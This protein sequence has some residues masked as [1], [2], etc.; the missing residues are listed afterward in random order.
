MDWAAPP[1]RSMSTY[2]KRDLC[3]DPLWTFGLSL[4]GFSLDNW[5]GYLITARGGL[6]A[7]W[8]DGIK[9]T[10]YVCNILCTIYN[11]PTTQGKIHILI[12]YFYD[13]II[14]ANWLSSDL[15]LIGAYGRFVQQTW[16]AS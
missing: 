11:I 12:W 5:P 2:D 10:T 8:L 4:E 16:P 7:S 9:M 14:I 3:L 6:Y 15:K 13:F 1:C